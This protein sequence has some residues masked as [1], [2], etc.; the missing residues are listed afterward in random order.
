MLE[1]LLF[2]L[3]IAPAIGFFVNWLI[4]DDPPASQPAKPL[5]LWKPAPADPAPRPPIPRIQPPKLESQPELKPEPQMIWT[6]EELD[7]NP[8]A[9]PAADREQIRW[10]LKNGIKPRTRA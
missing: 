8:W 3:V 2:W 4:P 6:L 1:Q 7:R 10:E 9:L 5:P